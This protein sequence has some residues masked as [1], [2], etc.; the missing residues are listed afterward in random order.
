MLSLGMMFVVNF[1]NQI[2]FSVMKKLI[3]MAAFAIMT[4]L[5]AAAQDADSRYAT[6]LL[7]PGT[8]A[9]DFTLKDINGT[10]HTLSQLR[11]NYVVLDFWASWCPDC[12]KDVPMLKEL[13]AKYGERIKF[14]SVSF[15]DKKENWKNYVEANGMNWLNVSELKKWKETQIS[16]MY[17]IKWIPAMYLIDRQGKIILSTVMIE[18]MADKLKELHEL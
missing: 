1:I 2:N 8:E 13:Y 17:K 7:K 14:V 10:E 11:G 16:Q 15:D 6:E 12:R 3:F 5:G 4:V 9:P 18:K